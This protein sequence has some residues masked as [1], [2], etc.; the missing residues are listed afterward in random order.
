VRFSPST[1][2]T[3]NKE[4]EGDAMADEEAAAV[5]IDDAPETVNSDTDESDSEEEESEGEGGAVYEVVF[6][7]DKLGL[8]IAQRRRS[9]TIHV[10]STSGA[11]AGAG[12]QVGDTLLSV[13]GHRVT[14]VVKP[15]T[16]DMETWMEKLSQE[17]SDNSD[18]EEPGS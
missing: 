6:E 4:E 14:A 1:D 2:F 18:T 15:R 17:N 8:S 10:S 9:G 5:Q 3:E 16:I 12:I 7:Q 13:G 11:S